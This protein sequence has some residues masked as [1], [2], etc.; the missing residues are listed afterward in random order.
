MP[1][2]INQNSAGEYCLYKKDG[3]AL[4]PGSCH[5]DRAMTERMLRAMLA[6]EHMETTLLIDDYV[7]TRPGQPYRLFPF[8]KIVKNGKTREITPEFASQFKLPHFKPAIKLGSHEDTTPA[9]G[10][11]IGLEVRD[12]GLY[13]VPELN[14][15]G[16]QALADG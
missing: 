5:A 11:I 3:G 12:D 4:V 6:N 13:D 2:T 1:Y 8:G 10:H 16:E 15:K 7:A 14:E 9:G